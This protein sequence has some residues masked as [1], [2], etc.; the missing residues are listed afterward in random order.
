MK[1]KKS[2]KK[3][4]KDKKNG[5]GG[6]ETRG[7][8]SVKHKVRILKPEKSAARKRGKMKNDIKKGSR[9]M[10]KPRHEKAKKRRIAGVHSFVTPTSLG[11]SIKS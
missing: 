10:H 8:R 5:A 7:E 3:R 2:M 11:D 9:R 4:I 6:N 1:R